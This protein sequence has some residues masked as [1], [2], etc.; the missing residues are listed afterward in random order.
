M[1]TEYWDFLHNYE[2]I[3]EI[4]SGNNEKNIRELLESILSENY[5]QIKTN[6]LNLPHRKES[7]LSFRTRYLR[8]RNVS[9]IVFSLIILVATLVVFLFRNWPALN[10]AVYRVNLILIFVCSTSILLPMLIV[11]INKAKKEMLYYL[12]SVI[13]YGGNDLEL[14]IPKHLSKMFIPFGR[15]TDKMVTGKVKCQCDSNRNFRLVVNTTKENEGFPMSDFKNINYIKAHCISCSTEHVLFDSNIH[16]WNGFVAQK[17]QEEATKFSYIE[18]PKCRCLSHS[19]FFTFYSA[20]KR[21]I[22]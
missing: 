11:Y 20:G 14:P 3:D 6:I 16:G 22:H 4:I 18:C 8:F 17:K 12:K 9:Y 5:N 15:G 2:H 21:A 1:K 10:L 19:V 13:I 7:I